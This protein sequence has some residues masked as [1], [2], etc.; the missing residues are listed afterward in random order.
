MNMKKVFF[1]SSLLI[2]FI[3]MFYQYLS[4]SSFFL[5]LCSSLLVHF[6]F[7]KVY[8]AVDLSTRICGGDNTVTQQGRLQNASFFRAGWAQ[9][10]TE[11]DSAQRKRR[12]MLTDNQQCS[13]SPDPVDSVK[14]RTTLFLPEGR[15]DILKIAFLLIWTN[16]E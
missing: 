7:A 2:K 3:S 13:H 6:C 4:S 14:G 8:F 16:K 5:H 10:K 1:Y 11:V 12:R 9:L 15:M